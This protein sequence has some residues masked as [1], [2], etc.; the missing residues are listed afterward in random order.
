MVIIL[1]LNYVS[2]TA[3]SI[4]LICK[5]F[6]HTRPLTPYSVIAQG[7]T[8]YT[9]KKS[10]LPVRVKDPPSPP[11]Y[12]LPLP[13]PPFHS[14][15][16]EMQHPS[17]YYA[18]PRCD[19][20]IWTDWLYSERVANSSCSSTG[21]TLVDRRNMQHVAELKD[22]PDGPLPL[23]YSFTPPT[24]DY[25][26][27]DTS[28]SSRYSGSEFDELPEIPFISSSSRYAHGW[29]NQD[30]HYRDAS[31]D[32]DCERSFW[33][34]MIR[35]STSQSSDRSLTV[36]GYTSD[37]ILSPV[38]QRAPSISSTAS[39]RMKP[40]PAKSILSSSSSIRTKTGRSPPSVKFLEMP[41]VHYEED[42]YYEPERYRAPAAPVDKK[43]PGLLRR[44]F[45]PK[46]QTGP[47]RPAI[48]GPF[49][50][51]EAPPRRVHGG[52]TSLRSMKSNSSLRSV[53]STSSRLQMY[54]GKMTRK[55]P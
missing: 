48:S 18:V 28:S 52:G 55:D 22:I 5:I 9:C 2:Y 47:E 36:L 34:S 1:R 25:T 11:S 19:S 26:Y 32:S 45:G 4:C 53:L 40:P 43:K 14:L 51:S 6:Q 7:H 17:S 54:W 15:H 46:P 37:R 8:Y 41:T 27:S 49:P 13:G 29:A 44:I 42:Y 35:P 33:A 24:P 20:Q 38:R 12:S 30:G 10:R 3:Y 16:L 50:L 23:C 21:T 39:S 31:D